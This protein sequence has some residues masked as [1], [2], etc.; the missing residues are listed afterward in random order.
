MPNDETV[1]A[2]EDSKETLERR[3]RGQR[4]KALMPLLALGDEWAEQ[5]IVDLLAES[6]KRAGD[7]QPRRAAWLGIVTRYLRHLLSSEVGITTKYPEV[8]GRQQGKNS[9]APTMKLVAKRV[10]KKRSVP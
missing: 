8:H 3:L 6:L 9:R 7:T 1:P 4:V 10:R 5:E 2:P